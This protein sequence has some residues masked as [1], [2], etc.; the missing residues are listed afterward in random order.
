MRI[1]FATATLAG[2]LALAACASCVGNGSRSGEPQKQCYTASAAI[3]TGRIE[4]RLSSG[5]VRGVLEGKIHDEAN[6]YFTSYTSEFS[7][8]RSGE[9]LNVDLVTVIEDYTQKTNE[10]WRLAGATLT[11]ATHTYSKTDCAAR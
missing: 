4:L 2:V 3:F 11:T 10:T 1:H 6:A 5:S 7:G 9:T 8:E